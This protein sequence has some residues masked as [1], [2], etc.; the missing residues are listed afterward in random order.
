ML[1]ARNVDAEQGLVAAD[2][3]QFHY[4]QV[5]RAPTGGCRQREQEAARSVQDDTL[6]VA[7][8]FLLDLQSISV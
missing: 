2:D 4:V 7:Q 8:S 3:V 5:G 6:V 1:P